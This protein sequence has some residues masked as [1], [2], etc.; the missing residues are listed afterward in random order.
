MAENCECSEGER[1]RHEEPASADWG[2]TDGVHATVDSV[3]TPRLGSAPDSPSAN[4]AVEEL[5]DGDDT[6]LAPRQ[7]RHD[8]V[9]MQQ[10][11]PHMTHKCRRAGF[12]PLPA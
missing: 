11:G 2:V 7:T 12:L 1:R 3:Q 6:V 4:A 10:F 8:F 9:W 5:T